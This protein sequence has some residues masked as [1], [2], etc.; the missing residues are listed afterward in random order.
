MLLE[1]PSVWLAFITTQVHYSFIFD[2]S[3]RTRFFLQTYWVISQSLVYIDT[4][5]YSVSGAELATL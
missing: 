4:P 3:A 1:Q 5:C 2:F